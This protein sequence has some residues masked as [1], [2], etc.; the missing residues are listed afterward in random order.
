MQEICI[1]LEARAPARNTSRSYVIEAGKDLFGEWV[2]DIYYGRIGSKGQHR[3]YS[4]A[5]EAATR[6]L[7][8]Q[9][10]KRRRSAKR[11]IGVSYCICSFE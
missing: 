10:L 2:I 5:S 1:A 9:K 3:Q 8:A 4:A 11:R 6:R 7:I